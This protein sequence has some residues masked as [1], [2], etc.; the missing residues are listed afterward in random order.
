MT[1]TPPVPP[2]PETPATPPAASMP[3]AP[4]AMAGAP[5]PKQTLSL[6]AMI[7]GIA[8][9]VLSFV[10]GLGFIPG[11]VAIILALQAKAKEPGAPKFMWIIGLVGGIAGVVFGLIF[12]IIFI[13][14]IIAT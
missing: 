5:G 7:I 4:P 9:F 2:T 8:A 14:S 6:T 1:D 10:I 3:P 12:G 13:V 11:I